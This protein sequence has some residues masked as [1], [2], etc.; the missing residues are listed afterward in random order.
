MT[1][2]NIRYFPLQ[3][4]VVLLGTFLTRAVFVLLALA[5]QA[6]WF[7]IG[8]IMV[9]MSRSMLETPARAMISALLEDQELRD[10]ALFNQ[11]SLVNISRVH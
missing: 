4:W 5:T 9:G 3:I 2:S 11:Q 8:V 7:A 1:L 10:L 6:L